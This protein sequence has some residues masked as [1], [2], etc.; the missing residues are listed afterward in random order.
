MRGTVYRAIGLTGFV[1]LWWI[2]ASSASS[3]ILLPSPVQVAAFTWREMADGEMPRQ[4]AATLAR[5]AAAFVLAMVVGS[6]VGMIMGRSQRFNALA[7]PLLVI[8]LN[9]PVLV[10]VVLTYIWIGL[11]DGAAVVAVAIAKAP[12]VATTVREGTRALDRNLDEMAKVFR[13]RAIARLRHVTLPQLAPYMAA[14]GRSGLSITWKIVLVVELLGRPNGVGFAIN[15]A[16]QSF[17]VTGIIA[18]GLV[19]A[20]VM[21]AMETAV[22]QPLERRFTRWRDA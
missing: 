15:L 3:N 21:L 11:N 20:A 13:M 2:V 5:V 8:A 1:A 14:A 12:T 19:F 17:D 6:I 7:D 10:V 18:Y 22:L 16:F 4:M 9:V